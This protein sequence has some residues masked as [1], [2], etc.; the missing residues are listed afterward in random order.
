M[1]RT[2]PLLQLRFEARPPRQE[3][4]VSVVCRGLAAVVRSR[5]SCPYVTCSRGGF[6]SIVK[7]WWMDVA[8]SCASIK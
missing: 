3:A 8:L 7:N 4:V 6:L 2:S 5:T 1:E